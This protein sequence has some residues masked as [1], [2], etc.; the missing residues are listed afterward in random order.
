MLNSHRKKGEKGELPSEF[1]N[2]E[3]L[4]PAA[5]P[6]LLNWNSQGR[7]EPAPAP[8]GSG[9]FHLTLPPSLLRAAPPAA[10]F[11]LSFDGYNK[12]GSCCRE[13]RVT[14]HGEKHKGEE[15]GAPIPIPPLPAA[16]PARSRSVCLLE[17]CY[18]MKLEGHHHLARLPLTPKIN[19]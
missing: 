5:L 11:L 13:L 4:H 10:A 18:I 1:I 6:F 17:L 7:A 15:G 12:R 19:N 14:R 2:Q 9:T 16:P 8:L 3:P